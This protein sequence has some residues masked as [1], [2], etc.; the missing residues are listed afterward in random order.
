MDP[1]D[2]HRE[3][4]LIP[5]NGRP[6]GPQRDNA[7][8]GAIL[9]VLGASASPTGEAQS[10]RTGVDGPRTDLLRWLLPAFAASSVIATP[11]VGGEL[12]AGALRGHLCWLA[13]VRAHWVCWGLL[14]K[15]A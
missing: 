8:T 5:W 14:V 6:S 13:A 15:M 2:R 10:A 9:M 11:S 4:V 12:M 7:A 1:D 3:L